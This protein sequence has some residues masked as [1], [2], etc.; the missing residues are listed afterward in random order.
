MYHRVF[1]M[2]EDLKLRCTEPLTYAVA[3]RMLKEARE[4]SVSPT[5]IPLHWLE[6]VE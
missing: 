1:Y 5:E 4:P 2:N 3:M 6:L